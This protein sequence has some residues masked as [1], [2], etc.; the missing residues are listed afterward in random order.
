MRTT[1]S[2]AILFVASLGAHAQTPDASA[3]FEVAS[4]K[5]APPPTG[6]GMHVSFRGGPGTQD[7]S[8]FICENCA[9]SLLILRA[10]DIQ[11]YQ[12]SGP[13]FMESARFDVS[14]RI[15]PGAAKE[16]FRLMLQSL[17]AERF[18]MTFHRAKKEMQVFN[19]VVAKNGPKFKDYVEAPPPDDDER[20][21]N[22]PLKKD[23]NG[24]PVIPAGKGFSMAI[25][26]NRAALRSGG[27]TM[28]EL[29]VNLSNQVGQPVIDATGLKAKYEIAMSWVPGEPPPDDPGPTIFQALQDQLGLKL[30]SRKGQIDILVVDHLEKTPTDN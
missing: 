23:A 14:A 18:K 16:Q 26:N 29:A 15:P 25:T 1:A 7:P 17:L 22:G 3:Q 2:T 28:E 30:E 12:L 13:D 4:I 11:R 8:V 10:F 5:P 24:F 6:R 20:R 9:V 21:Q 27:G 19:L